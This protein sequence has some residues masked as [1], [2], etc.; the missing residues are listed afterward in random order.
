[1]FFVGL[2]PAL[3]ILFIRRSVND[4]PLYLHHKAQQRS[5]ASSGAQRRAD[6][7]FLDIFKP[8]HLRITVL[9]SLM[10][11]GMQ[12]GYYA[13]NV[14]LPTFL[15]TERKLTVIGTGG[16]Q[17][18]FIIGAFLGYLSGAYLSDRLGR[19]RTFMLFALSAGTLAVI[20]M[21]LPITD[22]TM[23]L[24]GFPLGFVISGIFSGSG[25]FLAE[26]F[27]TAIRG[28]GQGFCYNFGRGI[29]SM[30]PAAVGLLSDNY[31]TL[32]TA[33][34]VCAGAAYGLVVIAALLLPER[35]AMDLRE[36]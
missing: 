27:P 28:S 2:L 4:P 31:T 11:T 25:A 30:F 1:M 14:W 35:R 32:A 12:G 33:I 7:S 8:Q 26:L 22:A 29:G 21:L 9:A 10:F 19:L 16:Y 13:I 36:A 34:G 17:A 24:L 20:Y 15:S 5:T 23:L 6:H 18:M 3:L